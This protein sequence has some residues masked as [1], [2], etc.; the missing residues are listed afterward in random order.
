LQGSHPLIVNAGGAAG[1]P[2]LVKVRVVVAKGLVVRHLY[3]AIVCGRARAAG[4]ALQPSWPV[5]GDLL[6]LSVRHRRAPQHG[7][8][9]PRGHAPLPS[10]RD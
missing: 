6:Y 8:E 3:G 10:A 9:Q 2:S 7:A 5:A 1:T 4:V